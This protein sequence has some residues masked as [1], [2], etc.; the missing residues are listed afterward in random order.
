[1]DWRSKLPE[2]PDGE[3]IKAALEDHKYRSG[4]LGGLPLLSTLI[5]VDQGSSTEKET[6]ASVNDGSP[7]QRDSSEGEIENKDS[8]GDSETTSVE[9]AAAPVAEPAGAT[10]GGKKEKRKEER[11]EQTE[12][13]VP[14][15]P[16]VN[17]TA[18]L[19]A[20]PQ[21]H[22]HVQGERGGGEVREGG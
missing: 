14:E 1:M 18:N 4:S 11:K 13:K 15:I 10:E 3:R 17:V 9:E 22:V 6:E 20:S 8:G 5:N 7:D 19:P 2:H 12:E 21:V 16:P